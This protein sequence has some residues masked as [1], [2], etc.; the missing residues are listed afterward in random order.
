MHEI[1]P[2]KNVLAPLLKKPNKHVCKKE[3]IIYSEKFVAY[4]RSCLNTTYEDV[5]ASHPSSVWPWLVVRD[6][7]FIETSR[8]C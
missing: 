2:D 8:R 6:F 3:K 4:V 7:M 5:I 1:T